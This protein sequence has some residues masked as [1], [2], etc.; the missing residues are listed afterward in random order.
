MT[1]SE[2]VQ[3]RKIKAT[4]SKKLKE[5]TGATLKE[6]PSS[7]HK[8]DVYAVTPDGI[9]I[10]VEIIWSSSPTNFLRDMIMIQT[11][12]AEVKLVVVSPKILTNEKFQRQFEKVAISQRRLHFAMHGSF[13]DGERILNES[14]YLETKI[15]RIILSLLSQVKMR[16]K[17]IGAQADFEPPEPHVAN[18][19][20]EK[21]LSNLFPVRRYPTT[22]FASPTNTRFVRETYEKLRSKTNGLPFL[23]KNRRLYTFDDLK[24]PSSPFLPFISHDQVTEEKVTDWV[25]DSAKRNDLMNLL[26]SALREYCESRGLYYD[27]MHHRFICLLEDGRTRFFTWRPEI[28]SVT[29]KIA[30]CIKGK[31]GNILFCKHYAAN[32]RFMF[33][34]NNIFLKILPTMTFTYDGYRPI[35]SF[36]LASLMSRYLSKQYNNLYLN[37]VRFWGKFLSKLDVTTS[38]PVGKETIEIESEPVAA[39]VRVGIEKEREP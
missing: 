39:S 12:D 38:I 3:H 19:I 22:I 13:I 20:E 29:R 31:E 10:Y 11:S 6:Y 36:K 16:G 9:S 26:N 28:K 33:L 24:H 23:L 7:G 14:N 25:Q 18:K 5:W 35:R 4:I 21:I 15:R 34:D 30:T 17:A 1:S 8:L 32:L 37:L 27:K 2:S